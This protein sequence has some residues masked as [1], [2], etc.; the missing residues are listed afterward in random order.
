M[1]LSDRGT[2]DLAAEQ[3]TWPVTGGSGRFAGVKGGSI[4]VT[5]VGEEGSDLK[6]RL[7]S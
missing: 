6:I 7:E 2:I 4:R 3:S 1:I 5:F